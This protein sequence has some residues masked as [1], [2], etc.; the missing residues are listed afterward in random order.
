[1]TPPFASWQDLVT[2]DN[3]RRWVL[4]PDAESSAYW[5]AYLQQYPNQAETVRQAEQVVR[6]LAQATAPAYA[7]TAEEQLVWQRIRQELDSKQTT[8][9]VITFRPL[10]WL[11]VAAAASVLLALGWW[12][13]RAV[14]TSN[15]QA[16]QPPVDKA[17]TLMQERLNTSQ[18]PLRLRLADGSTVVLQPKSQLTYPTVFSADSRVVFLTGE[19]F[20]EVEKRPA[21]PFLVYAGQTVTRVLGTSF[22]IKAYGYEPTVQVSVR[23]GKVS[24]YARPTT[25]AVARSDW[26][27][28]QLTPNQ[29]AVFVTRTAHLRRELVPA[30]EP[31]PLATIPT[32]L[33]FDERPV[34]EVLTRLEAIYGLTID[35]NKAA[36]ANCTITTTFTNESL[37]KRL[38]F[39]CQAIGATYT[40]TDGQIRIESSGC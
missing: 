33:V 39:I 37:I 30:P 23:T 15:P 24:V 5:E 3:F 19:A 36:L 1:M 20:F 11:S 18:Q 17:A 10:R 38:S 40:I 31:L 4:K 21:Q 29:Q 34:N 32:E 12:Q 8:G 22:R 9:R 7:D 25:T 6:Q 35:Y 16:Y 26:K 13:F 14:S 2:N 28:V 27:G